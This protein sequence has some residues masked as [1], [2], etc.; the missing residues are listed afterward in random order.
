MR[1]KDPLEITTKRPRC[2]EKSNDNDNND[3]HD[4]VDQ[5]D[6]DLPILKTLNV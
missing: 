1:R 3:D 2:N 5:M 4:K 6:E